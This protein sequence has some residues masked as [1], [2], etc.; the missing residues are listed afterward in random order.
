MP[1]TIHQDGYPL[2]EKIMLRQEA[3]TDDDSQKIIPLQGGVACGETGQ[4]RGS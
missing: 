3:G 2:S 4:Q 1:S